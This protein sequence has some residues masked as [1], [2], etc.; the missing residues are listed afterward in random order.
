M[1]FFYNILINMNEE[2]TERQAAVL[3]HELTVAF[4]ELSDQTMKRRDV[5][6]GTKRQ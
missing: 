2:L 6:S 4:V 3:L 5:A 1:Q